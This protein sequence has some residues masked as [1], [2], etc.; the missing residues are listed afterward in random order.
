MNA[1]LL[2]R[3]RFFAWGLFSLNWV[4]QDYLAKKHCLKSYNQNRAILQNVKVYLL[5]WNE[6]LQH[7]HS[8]CT[9]LKNWRRSENGS[10]YAPHI[11]IHIFHI[12][13]RF[14]SLKLFPNSL[15][16]EVTRMRQ[17]SYKP[18]FNY[19]FRLTRN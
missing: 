5:W 7:D 19:F 6:S 15:R 1:D 2:D 14:Y 3:I 17:F 11:H 10:T 12:C 18:K 4:R 9:R 13:F 8:N 16:T